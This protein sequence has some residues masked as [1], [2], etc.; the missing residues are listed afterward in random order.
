MIERAPADDGTGRTPLCG[1][2]AG[3]LLLLALCLFFAVPWV[4]RRTQGDGQAPVTTG[5]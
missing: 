3:V 5:R 1:P 2:V 4:A